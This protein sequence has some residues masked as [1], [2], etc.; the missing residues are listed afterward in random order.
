MIR[1]CD[2]A[3]VGGGAR[4]PRPS[5]R[6]LR[7]WPVSVA[8]IDPGG[9]GGGRGG[10][11][12]DA[13]SLALSLRLGPALSHAR[14]VGRGGAGRGAA[15]TEVHV[16]RR[17]GFGFTRIRAGE[18]G[19]DALG[20]VTSAGS[21]ERRLNEAL[22]SDPELHR[23]GVR[24]YPRHRRV[25]RGAGRG[26]A[27]LGGRPGRPGHRRRAARGRGG[28]RG[29]RGAARGRAPDS[30]PPLRP[31]R[32]RGRPRPG[33]PAPG[34]RVR[35][36]HRVRPPRGAAP[37]GGALRVRV[38][39]SGADRGRARFRRSRVRGASRR[40]V[41]GPARRA[42]RGRAAGAPPPPGLPRAPHHRPAHP[43]SSATLR[44]PSTRS[45][46]QGFNLGLRDVEALARLL[47]DASVDGADPASVTARFAR[48][49][50]A[51]HADGATPHREPSRDLRLARS[52]RARAGR[53]GPVHP[54][55]ARP[56]W[57]R[58]FAN[59]TM[60]AGW[61][62]GEGADAGAGAGAGA[63]ASLRGVLRGGW[64]EREEDGLG[65]R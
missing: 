50:R 33:A 27:R 51:D 54:R 5:R 35:A 46:A 7:R 39:G 36:L 42:A 52:A 21:L 58:G 47:G 22:D 61:R 9:G 24:A 26:S 65:A 49:R 55:P 31:R 16:S 3:V 17:G 19:V 14:P 32:A 59:L 30:R 12:A 1:R 53:G 18:C 28:W 13:R 57:K 40:D 6:A 63:G 20:Y 2:V 60:G 11:S 10:G 29:L 45:G 62:W 44:T 8:L 25:G 43:C 38:G 56:R 15:I 41:R 37:R 4:R 23:G 48:A 64:P 34:A